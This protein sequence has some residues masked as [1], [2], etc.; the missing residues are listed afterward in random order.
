MWVLNFSVVRHILHLFIESGGKVFLAETSYLEN[1]IEL[2]LY[3]FMIR[4]KKQNIVSHAFID[5]LL[6]KVFEKSRMI[7][8]L[9]GI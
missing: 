2:S 8:L 4:V 6:W 5:V 3:D 1:P 9:L 7:P